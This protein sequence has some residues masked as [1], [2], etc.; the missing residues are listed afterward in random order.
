MKA[1]GI[2]GAIVPLC[3][4]AAMACSAAQAAECAVA[5]AVYRPAG[6]YSQNEAARYELVHEAKKIDVNMS[7]L[8]VTIR[9]TATKRAHE[10][11]FAFSNGYG[12]THLL[13]A[14]P[15]KYGSEGKDNDASGDDEGPGSTIMYFDAQMKVV[16]APTKASARA[17][18]FLLMPEIGV[19]FWYGGKDDR[20]F[21]PPDGMWRLAG[22][23]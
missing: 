3:L 1:N 2:F 22:C 12:R 19:K 23:R 4:T 13:Y 9:N 18:Q 20:K 17:P 16:E 7:D 21:V 14:G 6:G 15:D 8:V 10:F 11:G 5:K